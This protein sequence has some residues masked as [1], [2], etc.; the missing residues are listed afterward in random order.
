MMIYEIS[1]TVNGETFTESFSADFNLDDADHDVALLQG[2]ASPQEM[3]LYFV[4]CQFKRPEI[5][6]DEELLYALDKVREGQFELE[7]ID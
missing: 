4:R 2:L 1:K 3:M 6:T 7:V 5:F